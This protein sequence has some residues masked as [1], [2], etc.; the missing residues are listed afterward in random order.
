MTENEPTPETAITESEETFICEHCE[1]T[2]PISNAHSPALDTS[3]WCGGCNEMWKV[4]FEKCIHDWEPYSAEGESGKFCKKCGGFV[5]NVP[6]LASP[7]TN[8][9]AKRESV[10]QGRFWII[11]R[12]PGCV[13]DMKG[14]WPIAVMAKTLREFMDARPT[15]LLTVLTISED[16]CPS[17][18]D[19]PE[20]LMMLDGR[21]MSRSSKHIQTSKRALPQVDSDLL[22]VVV[23]LEWWLS[24]HPDG[25]VMRDV[26]R[27]A[28]SNATGAQQEVSHD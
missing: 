4:S 16:G 6:T 12:D 25:A 24:V 21:S 20:C 7:P 19:A 14:P 13:P 11:V 1:K 26:C 2:A 10:A 5:V 9:E 28:I 27:V 23:R 3:F 8:Y 15:S 17:V 22:D 18:Q